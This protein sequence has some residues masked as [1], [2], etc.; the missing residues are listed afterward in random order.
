MED[1]LG[2]LMNF[3]SVWSVRLTGTKQAILCQ[4]SQAGW[5]AISFNRLK[6]GLSVQSVSIDPKNA[7]TLKLSQPGVLLLPRSHYFIRRLTVPKADPDQTRTMLRLEAQGLLGLEQNGLEIGYL[8]V[9]ENAGSNSFEL[10]LARQSVLEKLVGELR[11]LGVTIDCVL[12]SAVA[13]GAVLRAC[14]NLDMLVVAIGSSEYEA[15]V[16]MSDGSGFAVRAI[17]ASQL[18]AGLAECVRLAR[19]SISQAD[20]ALKVGLLGPVELGGNIAGLTFEDVLVGRWPEQSACLSDQAEAPLLACGLAMGYPDQ[21]VGLSDANLLPARIRRGLQ[22][23]TLWQR[24]AASAA[25]VA[26]GLA[27]AGGALNL[28]ARAHERELANIQSQLDGIGSTG[29][30][31]GRQIQQL[32]LARQA[33]EGT[34]NF[35]MLLDDLEAVTP[36]GISYSR[37]ELDS[38]GAVS[39][40]GQA[41]SLSLPF[42][43]PQR[44]QRRPNLEQVLLRDAAQVKRSGG[45]EIEF[46]IEGLLK[47]ERRDGSYGI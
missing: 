19:Q 17:P 12:P 7:S 14:P 37:V 6:S 46:Y 1:I 20:R 33:T 38:A 44:L 16:P 4:P 41:D 29:R 28:S 40:Q 9:A 25:L 8:P 13:W 47:R 43:L 35:L 5:R 45:S 21:Q 23:R 15:V 32:R 2:R 31:I 24:L 39:L 27:L 36:K 26:V 22:I 34:R 3:A 18:N 10:Y 11:S 42:L 30:V